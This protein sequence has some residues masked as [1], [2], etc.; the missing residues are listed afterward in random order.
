M[1]NVSEENLRVESRWP[2]LVIAGAGLWVAV[3]LAITFWR[4]WD[5]PQRL[6]DINDVATMHLFLFPVSLLVFLTLS[7]VRQ[8]HNQ[9]GAD[10]ARWRV[11]LLLWLLVFLHP[12]SCTLYPAVFNLDRQA[13]EGITTVVR[14]MQVGMP[15]DQVERKIIDLNQS[16]P[17][18]MSIDDTQHE[19]EVKEVAQYLSTSDPEQRQRLR[20]K[21]VRATLVFVP[22]EKAGQSAENNPREQVFQRRLRRSSDI[23][24]DRIEVR[25]GPT[26]RL[27]QIIYSSNRQLTEVRAPCTIHFIVPAPPDTAFPYPCP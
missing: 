19:A 4:A 6:P 9:S 21:I 18:S 26:D 17:V 8:Q 23:G 5:I 11:T 1:H 20:S 14:T 2:S 7:W 15:R 22:V 16:L 10:H 3:V 24:V 12:V 27:E 25:Y 13:V